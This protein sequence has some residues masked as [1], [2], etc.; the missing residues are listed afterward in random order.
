M[1][2]SA[3]RLSVAG[4]SAF[5]DRD[6]MPQDQDLGILLMIARRKKTQDGERVR[7]RQVRQ[8]HQ[9]SRSSCRGDRFAVTYPML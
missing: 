4:G 3:I 5:Q 1:S 2:S 8:S 7:H 6:L 9:H